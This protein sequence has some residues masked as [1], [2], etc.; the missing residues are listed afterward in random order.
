MPIP[1][2]KPL[3]GA[4]RIIITH[5][6]TLYRSHPR[7]IMVCRS[8]GLSSRNGPRSSESWLQTA[9]PI[10]PQRH[11]RGLFEM[12]RVV[13][14]LGTVALPL[15]KSL[16]PPLSYTCRNTFIITFRRRCW[17]HIQ[18]IFGAYAPRVNRTEY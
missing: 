5:K 11:S 14:M 10:P 8:F 17:D 3:L 6:P 1:P 4:K 18:G 2:A 13:L 16:P 15:I 7:N 9:Y 12:R